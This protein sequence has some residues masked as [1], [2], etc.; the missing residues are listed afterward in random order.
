MSPIQYDITRILSKFGVN[1]CKIESEIPETDFAYLNA[2]S[3]CVQ[4]ALKRNPISSNVKICL[5]SR[6]NSIIEIQRLGFQKFCII[7][8][9]LVTELKLAELFQR[10]RH[11]NITIFAKIA[12]FSNFE[13]PIFAS[14]KFSLIFSRSFL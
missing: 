2:C 4:Q 10:C 8:K 9:M 13:L 7:F 11:L 3:T 1:R 14:S 12:C 5:K 6:S